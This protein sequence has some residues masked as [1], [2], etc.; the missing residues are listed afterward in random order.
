MYW[1]RCASG[2]TGMIVFPVSLDIVRGRSGAQLANIVFKEDHI[3]EAF[4]RDFG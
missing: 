3:A 2:L 1:G 4:L